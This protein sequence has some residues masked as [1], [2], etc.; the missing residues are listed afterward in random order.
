MSLSFYRRLEELRH[1]GG[2][3]DAWNTLLQE[4][5]LDLQ[6]RRPKADIVDK[7]MYDAACYFYRVRGVPLD[8]RFSQHVEHELRARNLMHSIERVV[9]GDRA[10]L[11]AL[12]YELLS[13]MHKLRDSGY[14]FM[15]VLD[16]S[17]LVSF[18]FNN[19]R[20]L[21]TI[22]KLVMTEFPEMRIFRDLSQPPAQ[23]RKDPAWFYYV[24]AEEAPRSPSTASPANA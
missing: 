4:M 3:D 2:S 6:K 8:E 17:L 19:M 13:T 12:V 15:T 11:H 7:I 1:S 18:M 9:N 5:R 20:D 14:H 22:L 24:T 21:C 23:S 16:S 10:L